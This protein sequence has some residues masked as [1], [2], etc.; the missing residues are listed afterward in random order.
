MI[1]PKN[2]QSSDSDSIE[3]PDDGDWGSVEDSGETVDV[4]DVDI[5]N[6]GA[7]AAGLFDKEISDVSDSGETIDISDNDVDEAVMLIL[8]ESWIM[9]SH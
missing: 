4:S 7:I 2:E 3:L 6:D 9:V 1:L 8:V 5:D